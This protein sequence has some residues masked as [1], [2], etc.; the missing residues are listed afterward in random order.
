MIFR[1]DD[2]AKDLQS[3][4]SEAFDTLPEGPHRRIQTIPGIGIQ[5]SA[6]LV[7][8][9][10]SIKRFKS[11]SALVGYFAVFFSN[12]VRQCDGGRGRRADKF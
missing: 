5:T 10:V 1:E 8:K 7:A 12:G 4:T 11:A 3:L 6:A 9:I 2:E